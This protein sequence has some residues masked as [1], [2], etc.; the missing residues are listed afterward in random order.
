MWS[1]KPIPANSM[2]EWNLPEYDILELDYSSN[3]R[4]GPNRPPLDAATHS[5]IM[6]ALGQSPCSSK[7]QIAALRL[8]SHAIYIDSKQLRSFFG[9]Y[10]DQESYV[11][12]AVTFITRV[13]DIYNQ[14][15]FR[16]RIEDDHM[17]FKMRSCIGHVTMFPFIQPEQSFFE[18]NLAN[19]EHRLVTNLLVVISKYEGPANL[20]N[21][22][23]W[24]EDG[25]KDP[26]PQGVPRSWEKLG[27]I[28]KGGT[29]T[30]TY[31]CAPENRNFARRKQLLETW[32]H[33]PTNF[34]EKDV[35]WWSSLKGIPPAVLAY[36]EFLIAHYPDMRK[37][38]AAIDGD[39]GNGMISLREFEEAYYRMG[40]RKF[41]GANELENVRSIFRYLDPSGEGQ[42]CLDEFMV[43]DQMFSE[44]KLSISEFVD[45]CE[46]MF[47]DS[48]GDVFAYLDADN[49][50]EI[51]KG[52]WHEACRHIGYLG[53][54]AAIFKFCDKDEEGTISMS[55]FL[56]LEEFKKP[57]LA[58]PNSRAFTYHGQ[59]KTV[60]N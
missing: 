58:R 12:L 5:K 2:S 54:C 10:K 51:D 48:L 32:G 18:L 28:P 22:E 55:E 17:L 25:V 42:V 19:R 59:R 29:L 43:L 20:R 34:V 27:D 39:G 13:I 60:S 52:E 30:L 8:S 37:A 53:P 35:L 50:G 7:A 56:V 49:S 36:L 1:N 45:F 24:H 11:E 6:V 14:K 31:N 16:V 33:W 41:R 46:R 47:G 40:C 26:L 3:R 44:V 38:F 23:Y 21:P 57:S 15:L 4:P 9:A